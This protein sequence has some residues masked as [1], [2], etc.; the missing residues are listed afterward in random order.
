MDLRKY[1]QSLY[2]ELQSWPLRTEWRTPDTFKDPTEWPL[3]KRL[4]HFKNR[5]SKDYKKYGEIIELYCDLYMQLEIDPF[6]I[7]KAQ[8]ILDTLNS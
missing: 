5:L 3:D 4:E 2:Q 8:K 7:N 6:N 1:N